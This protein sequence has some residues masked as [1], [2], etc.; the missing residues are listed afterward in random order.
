MGVCGPNY[1]IPQPPASLSLGSQ[2][3]RENA[4]LRAMR[5]PTLTP[6]DSVTM[7]EEMKLSE[8]PRQPE[9]ITAAV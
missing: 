9:E 2:V 8:L 1:A 5:V 7:G 4:G 6:M 3:E